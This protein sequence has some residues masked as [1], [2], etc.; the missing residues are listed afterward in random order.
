MRK[1]GLA[2][3]VGDAI[4]LG[5]MASPAGA[6]QPSPPN[7][8]GQFISFIAQSPL[9]PGRRA[10]ADTVFGSD[11]QSVQTAERVLQNVICSS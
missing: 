1:T 6:D 8:E 11:P 7:C 4:S 2:L 3:L 9:G 10:V 5:A